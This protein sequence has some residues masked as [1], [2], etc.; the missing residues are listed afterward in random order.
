M[1]K[2]TQTPLLRDLPLWRLLVA[3]ADAERV[4]GP[5]H[6]TTRRFAEAVQDRLTESVRV[7]LPPAVCLEDADA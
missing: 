4:F 1:S 6:R 3:L 7:K 5:T 2:S